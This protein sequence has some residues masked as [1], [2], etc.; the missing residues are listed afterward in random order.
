MSLLLG[1]LDHVKQA[2]TSPFESKSQPQ[3]QAKGVNAFASSSAGGTGTATGS[4][5]QATITANDFLTLLV[6]EIQNQD[7]TTQTDPMQY[8]TQ[9]VGVNSLEQL[10]QIN[11]TLTT[12]TGS[13]TPTGS[14]ASSPSPAAATAAAVKS[15]T[16]SNSPASAIAG[17]FLPLGSHVQLPASADTA[18]AN[19]FTHASNLPTQ[20][21]APSQVPLSPAVMRA[22]QHSIPGATFTGSPSLPAAGQT[23]TG[24]A[25]R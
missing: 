14:A 11:Q 19:A 2:V 10:V 17:H 4:P 25:V 9:L 23:G 22:L 15:A 13:V 24:G 7:P 18:V 20:A 6:T 5:N 8:I 3:A 21:L 1:I 12:A 16:T